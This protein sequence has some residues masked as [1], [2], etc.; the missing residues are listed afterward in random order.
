MNNFGPHKKYICFLLTFLSVFF[1]SQ[2]CD[3][4]DK[5]VESGKIEFSFS[6]SQISGRTTELSDAVA[7]LISVKDSQGTVVYD[8][9]KISLFKFGS[10]FLSEP[11]S[12]N[13]GNYTLTEFLV[14]NSDND[15]IYATPLS[16]SELA[17]LV[18]I[19]LPISFSVI[20]DQTTKLAPQVLK[21]DSFT[22][23]D[24]G[25]ATFSFDVV[26][27]F[28]FLLGVFIYNKDVMDFELTDASVVITSDDKIIFNK[29]LPDLTNTV[30]LRDSLS[31]YKIQ[32]SKAGYATYTKTFSA[33][34]LRQYSTDKVLIVTLFEQSVM[35]G[36][37]GEYLFDGSSDDTS[38]KNHHG[39]TTGVTLTS[40]RKGNPNSAYL[41][42][43]QLGDHI[44]IPHNDDMNFSDHQNFTISLWTSINP[45]QHIESPINDI[46]RK[47]NGNTEGY[48]FSI[49]YINNTADAGVQN[50]ILA[51]R[52]DGSSCYNVPTSYTPVISTNTFHHIIF[53]K[54][55]TMLRQYV[56]NQLVS[57]FT[58]FTSCGTTNTAN[59]TIGCRGQLVRFFSGIVDDVRFFNRAITTSEI[60][61]L[62]KE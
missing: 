14:L 48:P 27:T 12:L 45:N 40:D 25:Y 31:E 16:G 5:N 3:E 61:M 32:V 19:P 21:I 13:T 30:T 43:G 9:K 59:V 50:T 55:G 57:E 7:L 10:E 17:Y 34:E 33:A 42:N 22:P 62:F 35:L 52:Y 51:T 49:A 37:V 58:D 53:Q 36:L 39:T 8:K 23:A 15:V 56:D 38:G 60:D 4:D 54:E 41:F 1:L 26:K 29:D 28:H 20:K 11:I 2:S 24:F 47:W 18:D 44:V 6:Q 46:I